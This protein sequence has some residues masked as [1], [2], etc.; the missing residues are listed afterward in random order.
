MG[1]TGRDSRAAGAGT[2]PATALT[3]WRWTG[4]L[5]TAAIAVTAAAWAL[6]DVRDSLGAPP[7]G[8]RGARVRQSPQFRDGAF[9]NPVPAHVMPP[10][11]KWQTL[12]ELLTD[13]HKRKPSGEVPLVT[14]DDAETAP[15]DGLHVIWYGHSSALVEIEGR[16]VLFDPVWSVR[17]SPSSRVG[18]RRLHPPPVPLDR[19]PQVDAIVISHDHYDHLDMATVRALMRTQSAPFVVPLGVGAHLDRWGVPPARLIELDW[20]QTASIAGLRLTATAARHFSGR[21]FSR[22]NTLWASW[23][24]A[25]PTRRVF[26]SG[27]SGYFDGYAAIGAAHGPFD[28][29]LIQIGAYGSA[30]PDIHMTPEDGATAHLDLRGE[31]LIPLHWGTFNLAFHDWSEPVDRLWREAKARGIRLAVPRPGERV[32]VDEPPPVDGWWQAIA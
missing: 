5:A 31:L 28:V 25:G 21:A 26:Y 12:R 29:T 8:V 9:R 7:A 30:W 27:D 18:P 10:G 17:C 13:R 24:L 11:S 6:R 22:D 32:N 2:T 15:A 1:E 4:R 14:P 23:A 20:D 19:L 3:R 16:R